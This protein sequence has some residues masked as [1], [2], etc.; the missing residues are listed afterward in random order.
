[1]HLVHYYGI[2]GSE[3][4]KNSTL[5]TYTGSIDTKFLAV[6]SS[7]SSLNTFTSSINTTI[8]TQLDANTVISGSSQV[9]ANSVTNFDSNVIEV[10]NT[11]S[12]HSGSAQNIQVNS[13]GVGTA[14]STTTGEIRATGDVTAY[15]SSDIRLKEN[16]K[17]IENALNKVDAISGNT[18]DWKEGF[19]T[20]H[21]HK[22]NDVGVIAQ[23]LEQVLPEVVTDR[24]NGYKAVNYEK[25]VPLLIEAIKEL[26]KKIKELESK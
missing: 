9:N 3:E 11:T 13:L 18:Y 10:L 20:I 26:N 4:T 14:A 5:G 21:S 12:V 24:E 1:M 6:Q 17:P 15:Y 8:K 19:D 2:S 7:T 23:E 25:I 16:I 22:G